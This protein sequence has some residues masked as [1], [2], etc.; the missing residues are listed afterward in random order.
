MAVPT[1]EFKARQTEIPGLII[2][3]V[4]SIED[5]RGYFQEKY[6][7]A[8]LVAAGMPESFQLVQTN[9]SYNKTK[10]VAR[11][12]HAEPWFK[13]ISVANGRVF[14]A[15]VDLRKGPNF[16]KV[17]T[18]EV[19]K[20]MAVFIPIGVANSFQTL[21]DDTYYIYSVS[22]HWSQELY[23]KYVSLNMADPAL[24]ISWPIPIKK[25]VVSERDRA[26]PMLKDIQPMEVS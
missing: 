6:Q 24:A 3:D 7:K 1:T 2:F 21:T 26:H 9:I 4:S 15:Y 12:L 8:K 25:A 16:G 11:G 17:V 23:D 20:N 22:A 14:V 18:V 10:G 13:Y 5:D 19:D